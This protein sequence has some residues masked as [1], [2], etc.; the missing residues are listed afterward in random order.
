MVLQQAD[1]TLV[2]G[3]PT[4]GTTNNTSL[5]SKTLRKPAASRRIAPFTD[6]KN[7]FEGTQQT[8]DR[9]VD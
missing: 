6:A 3:L 1:I 5:C 8:N 4:A 9:G 7:F 2:S